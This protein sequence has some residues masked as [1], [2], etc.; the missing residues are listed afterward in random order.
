MKT[1]LT[2]FTEGNADLIPW[3]YVMGMSLQSVHQNW[4]RRCDFSITIHHPY[5]SKGFVT[6]FMDWVD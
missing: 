2:G 6:V 4:Q 1:L 3:F 5:I